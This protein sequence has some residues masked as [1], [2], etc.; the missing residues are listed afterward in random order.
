[1]TNSTLIASPKAGDNYVTST[2]RINFTKDWE[3]VGCEEL[4]QI[5]TP[6]KVVTL[7]KPWQLKSDRTGRESEHGML[8]S[9]FSGGWQLKSDRTGRESSHYTSDAETLER[10][11]PTINASI[12]PHTVRVRYDRDALTKELHEMF[13]NNDE[14]F[15]Y[16]MDSNFRT[17]IHRVIREYGM[18]AIGRIQDIMR[19]DDVLEDV[20]QEALIQ[21]GNS[22][23][24]K[25]HDA[26]L[27]LLV[28]ALE[29]TDVYIRDAAL[30]GID[31]LEDPK[32]IHNLKRAYEKEEVK[33]FKQYI[34]E[35]ITS[36]NS[37]DEISEDSQT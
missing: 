36:F 5:E 2:K 1:M 4:R 34:K 21:I 29:S 27:S 30:I 10:I 14:I 17:T 9:E 16:G 37:D 23:D 22:R 25:T 8:H 35:V 6:H 15:E 32:A 3:N 19:K 24:D 13:Y 20:K 12:Q 7:I 26:R 28:Q 11:W 18:E 33:W 31:A